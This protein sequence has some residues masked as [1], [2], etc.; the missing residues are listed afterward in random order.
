ML[1][2][3]VFEMYCFLPNAVIEV[4]LYFWHNIHCKAGTY[5][6]CC[7]QCYLVAHSNAMT[8]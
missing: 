6:S 1:Y 8:N 3:Y 5:V 2:Y 4:S 7:T